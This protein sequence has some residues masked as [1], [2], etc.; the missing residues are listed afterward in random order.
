MKPFLN[1]TMF[2]AYDIRGV[3]GKDLT[4]EIAL[5]IGKAYGTYIQN[6]EGKYLS[7]GRDNRLSSQELQDMFIR[8]LLSTGCD[9]INIGLS[10][11]PMLYFSVVKWELSGGVNITGSHN[12]PQYNGI[13]MTKKDAAPVAE[14]EIQEIKR[15]VEKGTFKEGKG[16]LQQKEIKNEYFSFLS[17]KV[18]LHKKIKVVVDAGNGTSGIFAPELLRKIGCDVVELYCDSDGTFPNHL[19]DPEMEENIKDLREEVIKQK[20]E[21]GLA[22]DG[23]G[24][25]V[26]IVDE[27]GHH[28]EGDLLLILLAR[29]FLQQNPGEKV[30]FD[31]KCSQNVYDDIK[32]NGGI[33]FLYKT[34]HS[35]IKKKMR[36][37]K[38]LLGGEISGH[39]FFGENSFVIDDSFQAACRLLYILTKYEKKLSDHLSNLRKYYSTPEI[40]VLCPDENKFQVVNEV[41]KFFLSQYPDS[42]TI[43]GIRI[44]FSTGWA[45]IRASNTSPYLTV[46]LEAESETA[47][48]QIKEIVV[49]KLKEF[50]TVTIP[51]ALKID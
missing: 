44:K 31:V 9:V 46:R 33:P 17:G 14:E 32:A 10:I 18:K 47:K 12:P 8:G 30:L 7:V 5:L 6:I 42:V 21:L 2:R 29:E 3:V 22:F 25:R 15:I 26:G 16:N 4:P 24:D 37:E 1:P 50:P 51:E 34:G 49:S 13:K 35:L 41:S 23:D 20:A 43:D 36:E 38:I 45:L 19:P 11:S 28:Y 39:M 27:T 40:K 48:E